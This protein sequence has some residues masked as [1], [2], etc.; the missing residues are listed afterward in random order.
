M[1]DPPT[2]SNSFDF[3]VILI[4]PLQQLVWWL[5]AVL[6]VSV[7]GYPGVICVTPMAWLLALRVGTICVTRSR[8]GT[9]SHRI[10][11][12]SLAGAILGLLQGILFLA[13]MP[14]MGP[15]PSD[16]I[17]RAII[18]AAIMLLAGIA[19][20]AGLSFFTAYFSKQRKRRTIQEAKNV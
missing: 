9:S 5:V 6:L 13:I 3:R 2:S 8:S 10:L 18:F 16:E 14:F 7:S 12:A 4:T 19:A 17:T 20:G 15:Y 11:E 1:I